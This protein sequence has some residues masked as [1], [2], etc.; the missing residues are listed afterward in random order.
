VEEALGTACY[1]NHDIVACH[2]LFRRRKRAGS[3]FERS[4]P[5]PGIQTTL[6]GKD[7]LAWNFGFSTQRRE[8]SK[9]T[10]PAWSSSPD[11]S[12]I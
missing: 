8:K 9:R 3:P 4:P 2:G 6:V 10:T 1:S 12:I 5:T 7:I 11:H